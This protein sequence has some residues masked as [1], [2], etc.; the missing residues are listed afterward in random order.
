MDVSH[1]LTVDQRAAGLTLDEPDDHLLRLIQDGH[2]VRVYTQRVLFTTLMDE[3]EFWA[4]RKVQP[5]QA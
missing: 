4:E 1:I 2:V 5:C 3:A